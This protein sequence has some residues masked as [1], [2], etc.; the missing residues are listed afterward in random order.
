M[1]PMLGHGPRVRTYVVLHIGGESDGV[2]P[3][4]TVAATGRRE[5]RSRA[6]ERWSDVPLASIRVAAAGCVVVGVLARALTRD[7]EALLR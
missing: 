1:A 2:V 7:G 5:A 6:R 4:G 3:L